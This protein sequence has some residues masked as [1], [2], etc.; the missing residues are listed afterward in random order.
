MQEEGSEGLV[1]VNLARTML[2]TFFWQPSL[3]EGRVSKGKCELVRR[4]KS[5]HTARS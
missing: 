5:S 2:V 1:L 3:K 4:K